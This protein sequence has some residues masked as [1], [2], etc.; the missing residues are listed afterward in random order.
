MTNQIIAHFTITNTPLPGKLSIEISKRAISPDDLSPG[1]QSRVAEPVKAIA[2]NPE[3][4][5]R[6]RQGQF[7]GGYYQRICNSG[8]GNLGPLA[9]KLAAEGKALFQTFWHNINSI[10]IE[11]NGICRCL[12]RY[13]GTNYDTFGGYQ[14]L[15]ISRHRNV[16]KSSSAQCPVHPGIHDDQHGTAIVTATGLLTRLIQ[17]KSSTKLNRLPWSGAVCC[18]DLPSLC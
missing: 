2:R 12:Y 3:D 1:V 8:L 9:S 13:G 7:R 16:S 14:S 6:H 15:R 4:V 10:D 17:G 11:V 18:R 5:Y